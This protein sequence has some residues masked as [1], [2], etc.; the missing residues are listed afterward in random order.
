MCSAEPVFPATENGRSPTVRPVPQ[1][2]AA[3]PTAPEVRRSQLVQPT[4]PARQPSPIPQ[5]I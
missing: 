3:A 2:Q 5:E 4:P 1:P